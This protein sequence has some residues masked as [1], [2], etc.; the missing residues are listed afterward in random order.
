[1]FRCHLGLNMEVGRQL[2]W[3]S[4]AWMYGRILTFYLPSVR[5]IPLVSSVFIRLRKPTP[6]FLQ[7]KLTW[8]LIWYHFKW[9]IILNF[10]YLHPKTPDIKIR[11]SLLSFSPSHLT[12]RTPS[13]L[14]L[15]TLTLT[16]PPSYIRILHRDRIYTKSIFLLTGALRYRLWQ[17][18]S[19]VWNRQ[20]CTCRLNHVPFPGRFR[21]AGLPWDLRCRHSSLILGLQI[22]FFSNMEIKEELTS[23]KWGQKITI[24]WFHKD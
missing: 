22:G 6:N 16:Q 24:G 1:M 7:F 3:G 20:S 5:Q 23:P 8:C 11:H 9:H 15:L 21:S 14:S 4:C 19:F 17:I 2:R 18:K 13:P 10:S 12:L